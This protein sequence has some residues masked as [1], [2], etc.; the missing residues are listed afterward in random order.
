[1]I[2]N[3]SPAVPQP[4]RGDLPREADAPRREAGGEVR[5]AAGEPISRA[6]TAAELAQFARNLARCEAIAAARA[7]GKK[8]ALAAAAAGV[9]TKW[10]WHWHARYQRYLADRNPRHLLKGCSPGRPPAVDLDKFPEARDVLRALVVNSSRGRDAGSIAM[11]I[12]KF[13]QEPYCPEEVRAGLVRPGRGPTE[14]AECVRRALRSGP[15]V[16]RYHRNPAETTAMICAR[17]NR[18]VRGADGTDRPLLPG[19]LLVPDDATVNFYFTIPDDTGKTECAR[20]W[21]VR[22]GRFQLLGITDVASLCVPSFQF[23]MREKDSYTADDVAAFLLAHMR[24]H[25]VPDFLMLEGGAWQAE[26]V[27]GT[28][29]HDGAGRAAARVGGLRAAGVELLRAHDANDKTWMEA[30][31]NKLWTILTEVPGYVGRFRGEM[32]EMNLLTQRLLKG[33]EDPRAHLWDYQRTVAE[34]ERGIAL[35]NRMPVESR[36]GTWVPAEKWAASPRV[37]N[38]REVPPDL[39]WVLARERR[40]WTVVGDFVQGRLLGATGSI[41]VCYRSAKL[42][43]FHGRKVFVYADGYLPEAPATLVYPGPAPL[44]CD[45]RTVRPGDVIGTAVPDPGQPV[46]NLAGTRTPGEEAARAER[47]ASKRAV[48]RE[49]RALKL[50]HGR[51]AAALSERDNGRGTQTFVA[52]GVQLAPPVSQPTHR[53]AAL[54]AVGPAQAAAAPVQASRV[55]AALIEDFTLPAG[56]PG[57]FH[58]DF[59]GAPPAEDW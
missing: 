27:Q 43:P 30:R 23:V 37:Q 15:L 20:R 3:L 31:W 19:E 29:V 17:Q 50:D 44:Q 48:G 53:T 46:V 28:V 1:M 22:V 34:V 59:V 14:V 9:K 25:G 39:A 33:I 51:N 54:S 6:L 2:E 55:S 58:P 8:F 12:W 18:T 49:Y 32:R 4:N 36:D 16:H 57:T 21:G 10:A 56:R 26:K 35:M 40:E 5:G 11:A 13:V 47:L 41:G 24:A 45:G 52:R 7:G 42:Q 38:K